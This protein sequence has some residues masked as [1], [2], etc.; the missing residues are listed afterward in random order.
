ML[1]NRD[2]NSELND[3]STSL[4]EAWDL[5]HMEMNRSVH[6]NSYRYHDG[7]HRHKAWDGP[8]GGGHRAHGMV[9]DDDIV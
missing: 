7:D 3:I 2:M 1:R 9:L 5:D 6:G 8:H 4:L